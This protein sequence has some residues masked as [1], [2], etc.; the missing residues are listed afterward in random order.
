MCVEANPDCDV[1]QMSSGVATRRDVMRPNSRDKM[2]RESNKGE[3]GAALIIALLVLALLIAL[4]MG[5]SLTAISEMGVSNTYGTQTVA[6]EAAEAGLNHAASLVMNYIPPENSTNPGFTDL[7]LLRPT[8][9]TKDVSSI[10]Y[11]VFI[12]PPYYLSAEYNPFIDANLALAPS[13][14]TAGAQMINNEDPKRGYQLRSAKIDPATG[15]PALVPGAFYKVSLIDDEPTGLTT[16]SVPN[17]IPGPNFRE[18]LGSPVGINGNKPNVDINNRLVIYSVGTYANASVTLE[19]WVAFLPYPALAANDDIHVSGS[20]TV[21]GIYGGVHSNANLIMDGGGGNSWYVEQTFTAYGTLQP[22]PSSAAGHV[23]GFYGGGQA[24]LEIPAFVTSDPVS[25]GGPPTSPRLQ[26]FLIRRADR[27]LIDPKFADGAHA[28]DPN[29]TTGD[30]N[31]NK[32]TRRLANLAERLG[33]NYA[34]L[35]AQ[36]DTD[37][38]MTKV[39][40]NNEAAVEVTRATLAG[41]VTN[42]GKMVVADTGWSYSGGSNASWGILTNN[43]GLLAGNK[44]Y[45]VIGVDNY[46]NGPTPNGGHVVLTGN[47]GSNGTPL[48]VTILSTGSIEIGG[49][50]NMTANLKNLSSPLLPP[51]DRPNILLAAVEDIKINGDNNSAI[52]FTGVSYA[53]EQ[54]ELSGSGDINGQVISLSNNHVSG[55]PVSMNTI[56]GSFNLTLNNGSSIGNIKLFSWR[57]IKQ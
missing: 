4:T 17:F 13:P 1:F 38:S 10:N 2:K 44:T 54:V 45:Y 12:A 6:L 9:T 30:V 11:P 32:A 16:P 28:T 29:D 25:A 33:I 56:T 5:I 50:P 3:R 41:A 46:N 57:Q 40:Q 42:V 51:F 53:G 19:G 39:Q 15:Q 47:V 26:D 43:N 14:F 23:G 20:T 24:K 8:G 37:N 35:A 21:S 48:S 27:L 52:A 31:G 34:D 55:S 36:L 49:T 7:L 18:T 22:D